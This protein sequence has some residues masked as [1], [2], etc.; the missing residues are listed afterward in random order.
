[1]KSLIAY[2][3]YKNRASNPYQALLYDELTQHDW[4]VSELE[5]GMRGITGAD[6]VH[7][8]WPDGFAFHRGLLKTAWRSILLLGLLGW[9]RR[10]GARIVWTVHNLRSEDRFH[11][12]L[13]SWFWQRLYRRIDG[14]IALNRFTSDTVAG[15][16]VL[17]GLPHA[18][19]PHGLYP[20]LQ[21]AP[22]QSS[23]RS[24]RTRLLVF[25]KLRR[26]KELPLLLE[27]FAGIK[28][29]NISLTI[30]GQC[31]DPVLAQTL[32]E[33]SQQLKHLQLILRFLPDAE[34]D[35][36]LRASDFVIIPYAGALNSGAIFLALAY[37]KRVIAPATPGF[38][39]IAD[40]FGHELVRL[41]DAPLD[42]A[43]LTE[44]IHE[45][46]AT[47]QDLPLPPTDALRRYSWQSIAA[48]HDRFF[49]RLSQD[50]E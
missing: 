2:P 38:I 34:L 1:M 40:D 32:E 10:R 36:Q 33:R 24:R 43:K 13:E 29:T 41:F 26:Y 49:S 45:A 5:P 21:A 39:E 23:M 50:E 22:V 20:Q 9:Y 47:G 30:A 11:P 19:I 25:G 17:R 48:Q 15:M 42:T 14:W 3:A 7:L 27:A 12:R 6:I 8:H 46:P 18:V 16:P 31:E 28:D 4:E 44:V 37:G 35:A